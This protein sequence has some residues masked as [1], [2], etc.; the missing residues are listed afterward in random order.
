MNIFKTISPILLLLPSFAIAQKSGAVNKP[1][2]P[3]DYFR[4]P[5]DI[6]IFLAGNFGECRPGH[7]HSGI[8]IKTKGEEN[9]P[10]HAAGDGYVSRIKM[11]K[12]GFGHGLYI[13]HP[14]GYT[15]LYAHLNNF[16]PAIQKYVKDKQYE[17]QRWDVDLQLTP[18]QF[19]V[20]KG[21]QIAWSG[22]TG[23]S[24]APHLH[25]EIRNSKTEHPLNPELF[26]LTIVDNI[27]P[28]I[29]EIAIDTGNIYE[30]TPLFIKVTNNNIVA[31]PVKGLL[32]TFTGPL[33]G[34]IGIGINADDFMNGSDNSL[35]FYT[36]KLYMDDKLQVQVTLDDIG[37]DETRYINAYADYR[38]KELYKK[39]VQSLFQLPGNQ[40]NGIFSNLNGS[41]GRLD[42]SDGKA[43]KIEIV[44][45]DDRNNETRVPFYI[46]ST[47][48]TAAQSVNTAGTLFA[49][50]KVNSY[51]D[52]DISFTLDERQLYD[53]IH[54]VLNRKSGDGLSDKFAIHYSYV[55]LHH[56]FDLMIKPNK[57]IPFALRSKVVLM[58]TDGKDED[59]RAAK[60]DDNGWYKA[61][62]RNFGTYWLA[63]DTV[64]PVIKSAQKEG[65]IMSKAKQILFTV[66]DATTSVKTFNGYIDDKWVCV[67]QHGSA[68]FYKFDEH[69]S[70]GKHTF[71]LKA[72]DEN[73]NSSSYKLTFTR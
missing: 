62:V 2:Y 5:L 36:A 47:R 35:T 14:N 59:G 55:P 26:G 19:P 46:R 57:L 30:S 13:T 71:V 24:T 72:D 12:G 52:N 42:I 8:D 28:I 61:A 73:G 54:F 10:V 1:D 3:Q 32:D 22:N 33:P 25:F 4:N 17:K 56:N 67:E 43:H 20:K 63:I 45:A 40:L 68:F 70:K 29:R 34:M 41:K 9:E 44:L 16:S 65:A 60:T 7:F 11:E 23:A 50:N 37:Y 58:Y 48:P 6:P 53:D 15:T 21:D 18:S 38:T 64:P 31:R 49:V 69:C 66:K 51:K 39:W 27:A